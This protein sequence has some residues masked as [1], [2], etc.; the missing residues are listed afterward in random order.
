M[1]KEEFE[2]KVK[3]LKAKHDAFLAALDEVLGARTYEMHESVFFQ[4]IED[5]GNSNKL[6]VAADKL[7][8]LRLW[9]PNK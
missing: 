9:N 5:M 1:T 7:C 8:Q 6:G 2:S 4:E 3:D